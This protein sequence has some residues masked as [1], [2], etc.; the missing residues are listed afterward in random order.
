MRTIV[1]GNLHSAFGS[2]KQQS[3]PRWVDAYCMYVAFGGKA[4]RKR[5]PGCSEIG[6]LE[7]VRREVIHFVPFDR[8]I[9]G[10]GIF[11][12]RFQHAYSAPLRHGL[13]RHILPMLSAVARDVDQAIVGSGPDQILLYRRFDDRENRVVHFDSSVVLGDWPARSL[14]F[15]LVV[16]RQVRTDSRP[17]HST[18]GR[19]EEYFT[20][21]IERLRI[22]W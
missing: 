5:I 4:V 1:E 6:G 21:I 10:T 18:V 12:R 9:G 3:R 22:V 8:R 20:R 7:N 17:A 15:L 16:P 14:L 13:R 11:R 2:G 19:L